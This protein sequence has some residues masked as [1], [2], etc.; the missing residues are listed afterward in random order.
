MP[1]PDKGGK[2][3]VADPRFETFRYVVQ[4]GRANRWVWVVGCLW[5]GMLVFDQPQHIKAC[6]GRA[7]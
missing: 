3:V 6:T 2:E 5:C 7:P 1:R 4:G